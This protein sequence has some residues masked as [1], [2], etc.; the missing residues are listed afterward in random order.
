MHKNNQATTLSH[1]DTIYRK[2][3]LTWKMGARLILLCHNHFPLPVCARLA[4]ALLEHQCL[5]ELNL[6]SC[7]D[8]HWHG[9]FY[10]EET[11]TLSSAP[12]F[13]EAPDILFVKLSFHVLNQRLPVCSLKKKTT[14]PYAP[15]LH[16]ND[17]S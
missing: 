14:H 1:L 9:S 15:T 17:S 11:T 3:S 16:S 5:R 7:I 2:I 13:F 12:F 10:N 8:Q 6:A 4:R